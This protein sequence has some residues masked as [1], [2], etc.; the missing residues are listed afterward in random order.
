MW[1]IILFY[2]CRR[3]V[4]LASNQYICCQW[5]YFEENRT[6]FSDLLNMSYWQRNQNVFIFKIKINHVLSKHK[7]IFELHS[8][9]FQME[10]YVWIQAISSGL[11][12][13]SENDFTAVE[14]SQK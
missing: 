11:S 14:R 8:L 9:F 2:T 6:L 13:H 1:S 3:E 10:N 4:L 7:D 5:A 12:T